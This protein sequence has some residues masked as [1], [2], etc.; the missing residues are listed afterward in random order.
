MN[1]AGCTYTVVLHVTFVTTMQIGKEGVCTEER[2][3]ST[4][5][6]SYTATL[7]PLA[8]VQR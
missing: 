3:S 4:Q 2:W 5:L 1:Q 8:N 6:P 7:P